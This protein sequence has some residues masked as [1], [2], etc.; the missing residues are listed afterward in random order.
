MKMYILDGGRLTIRKKIYHPECTDNSEMLELPVMAFLFCHP[1]GKILFDTGCHPSTSTDSR[2]RWGKLANVMIPI[3]DPSINVINGLAN[4]GIKPG[5]IDIVV[6]SHLHPDHCGCNE[7]FTEASFMV[8]HKELAA[9][10]AKGSSIQGYLSGE[11]NHPMPMI[12]ISDGHDVMGDGQLIS[13]DLPGHTPGMIG[14]KVLLKNTGQI[15]LVSDAVSL[16]R[17]LDN[18]EVP[19]NAWNADAL[20]ESYKIIRKIES[21]GSMVICG[22]DDDQWKSLKKD[23][24]AY[25]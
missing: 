25:D 22:H 2:T 24:N 8:H 23:L 1:E 5:D 4:L 13:V 14:L 9:A 18:D 17:N 11:W 6:N 19:R 12:D 3:G 15:F 10:R 16:R 21:Q 7:F 20:I